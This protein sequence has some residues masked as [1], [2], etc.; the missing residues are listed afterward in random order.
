MKT[1]Y[2]STSYKGNWVVYDYHFYFA[3]I[4]HKLIG[5]ESESNHMMDK[6]YVEMFN[7]FKKEVLKMDP[8]VPFFWNIIYTTHIQYNHLC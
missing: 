8:T 6:S 4:K 5:W 3:G 7:T 1:V 2:S